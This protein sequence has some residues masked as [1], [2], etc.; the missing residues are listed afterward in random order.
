LVKEVVLSDCIYFCYFQPAFVDT[1]KP[2]K[3]ICYTGG[4]HCGIP[5]AVINNGSQR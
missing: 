2:K 1:V 5:V 4:G 3:V